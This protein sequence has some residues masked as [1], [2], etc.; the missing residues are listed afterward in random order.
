MNNKELNPIQRF[1]LLI[2][3]DSSE[4]RNVYIYAVFSGLLALSVPISIQAIIN[5]IVGG[6]I[7]TSWVVLI[8]FVILGIIF[9]GILLYCLCLLCRCFRSLC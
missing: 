2:K 3:P 7:S 8:V 4:I 6:Q 9:S 5:L 1:F